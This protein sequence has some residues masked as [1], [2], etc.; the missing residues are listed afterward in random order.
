MPQPGCVTS[1]VGDNEAHSVGNVGAHVV[2]VAAV[3]G[4][5]LLASI[6]S[7]RGREGR[8]AAINLSEIDLGVEWLVCVDSVLIA[9]TI[10]VQSELVV[11]VLRALAAL[12]AA[13]VET[14]VAGGI[15]LVRGRGPGPL[16]GLHEIELGAPVA[17]NLVGVTVAPAVSIHPEITIT[18]LAWHGDQVESSDA[19]TLVVGQIN[20]PLNRA[21]K[22]IGLEVL[23][24][25]LLQSWRSRDVASAIRG[26][27]IVTLSWGVERGSH[28]VN[29]G[30]TIDLNVNER[31][32]RTVLLG[33]KAIDI[34]CL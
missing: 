31:E 2:Q 11:D 26:H 21:A 28:I 25:L 12:V 4:H 29:V 8:E 23:G 5:R 20:V 13:L 24:I 10:A 22:K 15:T 3:S 9:R 33:S 32:S 19:A 27:N 17:I 30:L 6:L 18:I 1:P 7:H 34:D 14:L 16:V